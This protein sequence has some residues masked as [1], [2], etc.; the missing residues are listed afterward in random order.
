MTVE[1]IVEPNTITREQFGKHTIECP[2]CGYKWDE[3]SVHLITGE[4]KRQCEMCTGDG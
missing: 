4:C 3:S 2:N 1:D